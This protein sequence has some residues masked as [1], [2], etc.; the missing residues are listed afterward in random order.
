ME[1][2]HAFEEGDRRWEVR[3]AY[4]ADGF[5]YGTHPG[6]TGV[7]I[8]VVTFD[9]RGDLAVFFGPGYPGV[10]VR[11][12][13]LADGFTRCT[14]NYAWPGLRRTWAAYAERT[15]KDWRI[16]GVKR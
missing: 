10:I 8:L 13:P 6:T 3:A 1:R 11:Q 2:I 12:E 9:V 14:Y 15:I 5:H 7:P 16:E 4:D